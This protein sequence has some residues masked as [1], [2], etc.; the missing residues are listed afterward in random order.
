MDRVP[1]ESPATETDPARLSHQALFAGFFIAGLSGFGGVLPFARHVIVERRR[2]LTS[3]EF[4]DLF[5]LCQFLPGSNVVNLA[6]AFGARHRGLS[7]AAA[8][9]LGLLAAPIAIV[10]G[11][12]TL[13]EH[14]GG[15]PVVHRT[16]GGLAAAASGLVLGTALKIAGPSFRHPAT[17]AIVALAFVLLAVLHLSLP[18]SIAIALPAAL[19]VAGRSVPPAAGPGDTK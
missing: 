13:Y 9:I 16:L 7:G 4:A 2:W 6:G 14:Y 17:I 19:L 11:L 12:G 8:A 15:L 10:I 5:S 3:A 18:A 1:S